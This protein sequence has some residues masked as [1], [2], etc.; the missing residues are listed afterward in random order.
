[1]RNRNDGATTRAA[2]AIAATLAFG[3]LPA[4]GAD[5][6][7][8]R[9]GSEDRGAIRARSFEPRFLT[10]DPMRVEVEHFIAY[11]A[12]WTETDPLYR[13]WRESLPEGVDVVLRPVRGKHDPEHPETMVYYVATSQGDGGAAHDAITRLLGEAGYESLGPE[14]RLAR[15]LDATSIARE[16]FDELAGGALRETPADAEARWSWAHHGR[17]LQ[18]A[19]AHRRAA[20]G[21]WP[22]IVV[23]GERILVTKHARVAARTYRRANWLI[24]EALGAGPSHDGPTD[25]LAFVKHMKPRSGEIFRYLGPGSNKVPLVFNHH[26]DEIW[27]LGTNGSIARVIPL[28]TDD[29]DPYFAW[30]HDGFTWRQ[31]NRWRRTVGYVS[32]LAR[33]G[34]PQRYGAFVFTDWLSNPAT[35]P[36][37]IRFAGKDIEIE[38]HRNGTAT[39]MTPEGPVEGAWWLEAGNLRVAIGQTTGLVAVAGR[40]EAAQGR[41]AKGVAR[42]EALMGPAPDPAND[43]R[44]ERLGEPGADAVALPPADPPRLVAA[45]RGRR[46]AEIRAAKLPKLK[47]LPRPGTAPVPEQPIGLPAAHRAKDRGAPAHPAVM[48]RPVTGWQDDERPAQKRLAKLAASR[49]ARRKVPHIEGVGTRREHRP[50]LREPEG[51]DRRAN[52]PAQ[53][54]PRAKHLIGRRVL[55]DDDDD[56]KRRGRRSARPKP[57]RGRPRVPGERPDEPGCRGATAKERKTMRPAAPLER[58]GGSAAEATASASRHRRASSVANASR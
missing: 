14:A 53:I 54:P 20:A 6:D 39:A 58:G 28:V 2:L 45:V 40:R 11:T 29:P 48:R 35:G 25:L 18:S 32:F 31:H 43:L 10:P 19:R 33:D 15:L 8:V 42:P 23:N 16:T 26:R 5:P 27:Q 41:G 24:R 37:P 30:R 55:G 46:G 1:M 36:V 47:R 7:E 57:P 38:F 50:V 44:G 56:A 51:R 49:K 3:A 52:E 13:A 22:T 34:A 17:A 4:A 12:E 9:W 21:P